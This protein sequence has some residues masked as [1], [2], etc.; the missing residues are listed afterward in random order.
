[1]YTDIYHLYLNS[2]HPFPQDVLNVLWSAV[3]GLW[4]TSFTPHLTSR[5]LWVR[6]QRESWVK[7]T[8]DDFPRVRNA[9]WDEPCFGRIWELKDLLF[10]FFA[11]L[12]MIYLAFELQLNN[13]FFL[14]PGYINHASSPPP[15]FFDGNCVKRGQFLIFSLSLLIGY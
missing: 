5:L 2:L 11:G 4:N 3:K 7:P 13:F 12:M 1:M 9:F 14:S 6:A 8:N 15:Y 10:L